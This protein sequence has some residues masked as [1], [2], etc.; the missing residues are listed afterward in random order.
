M[1][2]ISLRVQKKHIAQTVENR[3][4]FTSHM[5][6]KTAEKAFKLQETSFEEKKY[7]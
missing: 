3:E 7:S 5:L 4:I 1:L 6:A 2:V